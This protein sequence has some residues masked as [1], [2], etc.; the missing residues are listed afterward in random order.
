LERNTLFIYIPAVLDASEEASDIK[1]T[2]FKQIMDIVIR[3]TFSQKK[4]YK[5]LE[6]NFQDDYTKFIE[7]QDDS[8]KELEKKMSETLGIYVPNSKVKI[9]WQHQD[10]E[11]PIPNADTDLIEDGYGTSVERCGH[12]LQRAYIMSMFQYLAKITLEKN[13]DEEKETERLN[14]SPTLI[15][16]IEEPEIYQHP[17]MQRY[18]SKI[19]K[20]L[21]KGSLK[22]VAE[23]I[24]IVYCTHS[25]LF[26]DFENFESIR[27]LNKEEIDVN[28]PYITQINSTD[29][30]KVVEFI[31]GAND[32]ETLTTE[33]FAGRI[34][35]IMTPWMNEGFFADMIV[36]VEGVTDR[37]AIIGYANAMKEELHEDLEGN[38]I[39]V[40]PCMS[41]NNIYQP[42]AIFSKL[43]IPVYCLWDSDFKK[44]ANPPNADKKREQ[45]KEIKKNRMLLKLCNCEPEDWPGHVKENHACFHNELEDTLKQEIGESTFNQIISECQ[46]FYQMSK[47]KDALKRPKVIEHLVKKSKESGNLSVTLEK[48]IKAI[49]GMRKSISNQNLETTQENSVEVVVEEI[50]TNKN[51]FSSNELGSL[52]KWL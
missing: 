40:I 17:N 52:D 39:S 31:M 3:S 45:Q 44:H 42:Y 11:I 35:A 6:G 46:N 26:V 19:L 22:G 13:S 4:E 2:V 14:S 30:K 21:A 29:F 47:K 50:S 48:I 27:K 38:G 36:L 25:P 37:A 20:N 51:S 12:G 5:E 41:K 49:Y 24:Q 23:K 34:N 15:I 18:L 1:K 7:K 9:N 33:G 43:N 10:I 8:L 32:N 28:Q 16:G